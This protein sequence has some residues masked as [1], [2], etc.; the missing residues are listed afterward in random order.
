MNKYNY[1][2][3]NLECPVKTMGIKSTKDFKEQE[4]VIEL[5]PECGE[6]LKLIGEL[7]SGG[8]A[9]FSSMSSA[10]KKAAISK[11]ANN[12]YK[13]Y[14]NNIVEKKRLQTK[15]EIARGIENKRKK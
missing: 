14:G 5:C 1:R 3:L 6:K 13:K 8:F 7:P 2:C 12:H 4:Q 10:D 11:R 15:V 9:K